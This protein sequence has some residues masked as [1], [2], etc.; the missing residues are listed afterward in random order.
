MYV[1]DSTRYTVVRLIGDDPRP[2]FDNFDSHQEAYDFA[3]EVLSEC[4]YCCINTVRSQ[5]EVL[6]G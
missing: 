1:E 6:K 4:R 2:Y 5:K 3:M